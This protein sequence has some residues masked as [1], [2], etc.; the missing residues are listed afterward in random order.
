MLT[1]MVQLNRQLKILLGKSAVRLRI[2]SSTL[3]TVD[4]TLFR[5]RVLGLGCRVNPNTKPWELKFEL[6]TFGLCPKLGSHC[7]TP[8][9]QVP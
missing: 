9:N 5:P 6:L 2:S 4:V 8:K 7:G 3:P 1:V